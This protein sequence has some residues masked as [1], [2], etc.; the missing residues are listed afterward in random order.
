MPGPLLAI[1]ALSLLVQVL[2]VRE[3]LVTLGGDEVGALLA[4]GAWLLGGGAG[5]ALRTRIA[6]ER[7]VRVLLLALGLAAPPVLVGLRV[8]RRV[9]AAVPGE[10]LP[11]GQHLGIAWM[12]PLLPALLA[13][14]AFPL[15]AASA[16]SLKGA[17][18]WESAGGILGSAVATGALVLGVGNLSLAGLAAVLSGIAVHATG[19]RGFRCA[20]GGVALAGVA[21]LAAGPRLD[22]AS[23]RWEHP[24]AVAVGDTPTGRFLV[25]RSK[26]QAALFVDGALVGESEGTAAEEFVVLASL[27][28]PDPRR[29][30]V[31]GGTLEGLA[32]QVALADPEVL[33]VVEQDPTRLV[34]AAPLLGGLDGLLPPS[35][36]LH[37]TDPRRFLEAPSGGP[38]DLV[39]L[40]T[41]EPSSVLENRL[42]TRE[43]F[44]AVRDRLAP[45][46]VVALRIP[47]AENFWTPEQV[48]RVAS[49]V[50]ALEASFPSVL[51]VPG[52]TTLLAARSL[53][54]DRDPESVARRLEERPRLRPPRLASAPW[55]RYKLGNDRV[56]EIRSRIATVSAS[57]DTDRRPVA[58]WASWAVALGRAVPW[59]AP[60]TLDPRALGAGPFGPIAAA[61]GLLTVA[62]AMFAARRHA[63]T[64]AVLLATTA[65]LSGMLLESVVLIGFQV[66]SG[67]LYLQ[68]GLLLMAYLA[69][70]AAGSAAGGGGACR[71]RLAAAGIAVVALVVALGPPPGLG[72]SLVLLAS[73]G[74]GSGLLFAAAASGPGARPGRL[75]AA[76]LLGGAAG[77]LAGGLLLVPM[78]GL[79]ATA[80]VA[81]LVALVALAIA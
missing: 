81:G 15:A 58:V 80:A 14:A 53:P 37:G 61:L 77:A 52:P 30:L 71:A 44:A 10:A 51:V 32:A 42:F 40:A 11:L 48:R 19:G 78:A 26:G 17:Y 39:L 69:G 43:A 68:V 7:G 66:A 73:A 41:R 16:R 24:D 72:I 27:L 36:R 47:G 74:A 18:A 31:L 5:A 6:P 62:V 21:L 38:W 76:D 20:S 28:H 1:G 45:G 55:V 60:F 13:G 8:I 49:V 70:L 65:G 64:R 29:V 56:A 67:V 33:D 3:I 23:A 50:H 46:G 2:V 22:L 79:P 4:L 63:R 9:L 59:I 12:A 75:Y 34:R 57:P 54:I 25:S 35:A